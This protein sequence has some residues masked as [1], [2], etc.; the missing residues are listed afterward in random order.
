[1]LLEAS[2]PDFK[3]DL[4]RLVDYLK[5]QVSKLGVEVV[6][7]E[8][9]RHT[10]EAGGFDAVVLAAGSAPWMPANV[11]GTGGANVVGALDVLRGAQTGRNVIVIGGGRIGCDVA[12]FLA[13]QGKKV[14]ITTR[15]DDIGRDM[16]HVERPGYFGRLSQHDVDIHTGVHLHQVTGNGV[17]LHDRGGAESELQGDTVV[18]AAGL[19][20]NRE[21]FNELSK[22]EGLEVFA[23]GDCAE[24]RSIFEAIHEGHYAARRIGE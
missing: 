20:S 1:M 24:V 16:N 4:R 7:D 15:G 21:L 2:T 14:I 5:T 12:L 8:A 9:T 6:N 13:E 19:R 23:V 11:P 3:A 22:V 18:L 10:I 17:V